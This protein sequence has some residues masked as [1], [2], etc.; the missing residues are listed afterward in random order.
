MALFGE[1]IQRNR[2]WRQSARSTPP[3]LCVQQKLI[4]ADL[5]SR[6][7]QARQRLNVIEQ[8][9]IALGNDQRFLKLRYPDRYSLA[10]QPNGEFRSTVEL[11]AV[12]LDSFV[13]KFRTGQF[14]Q[15]GL[16]LY[17]LLV[18][19]LTSLS[20]CLLVLLHPY[21]PGVAQSWNEELR[22]ERDRWLAEQLQALTTSRVNGG[23]QG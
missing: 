1:W 12:G 23:G 11:V 4:E 10:F 5:R 8:Q 18:S 17:V 15:L 7:D 20:A 21:R 6:T 2:D 19:A 9:R 16:S 3:P 22:R 13:A 14:S